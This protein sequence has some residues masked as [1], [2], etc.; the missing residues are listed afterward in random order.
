MSQNP[1]VGR[2]EARPDQDAVSTAGAQA[3]PP[4]RAGSAEEAWAARRGLA[5]PAELAPISNVV[6]VSSDGRVETPEK[7]TVCASAVRWI[8]SPVT[9]APSTEE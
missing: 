6:D 5:L 2:D 8:T 4:P 9:R 3:N 7:V 1:P